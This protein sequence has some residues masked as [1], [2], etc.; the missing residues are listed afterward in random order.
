MRKPK[1]GDLRI[2]NDFGEYIVEAFDKNSEDWVWVATFW[3]SSDAL[4]FKKAKEK[5]GAL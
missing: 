4:L 3:F 1:I 2:R 5:K